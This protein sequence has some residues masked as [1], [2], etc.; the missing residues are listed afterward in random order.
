MYTQVNFLK[1]IHVVK[2]VISFPLL[3]LFFSL[4]VKFIFK[5]LNVF[6]FQHLSDSGHLVRSSCL[7]LLGKLGTVD[8]QPGSS[9]LPL[10][11]VMV[12]YMDDQDSRVRRSAFLAIVSTAN[13]LNS[14]H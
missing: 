2:N 10:Q 9:Q 6:S 5:V 8:S 13:E 11:K 3:F 1:K 4:N 12:D 7:E 14:S